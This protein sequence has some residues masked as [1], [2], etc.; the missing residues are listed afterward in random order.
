MPPLNIVD[1]LVEVGRDQIIDARNATYAVGMTDLRYGYTHPA[2]EPGPSLINHGQIIAELSSDGRRGIGVAQ[3]AGGGYQNSQ[4]WNTATGVIRISSAFEVEIYGYYTGNDMTPDFRN[5]GLFTVTSAL[6]AWGVH[7]F[8]PA[9]LVDGVEGHEFNFTNTGRLESTG[10]RNA[11]GAALYNGGRVI[12]TGEIVATGTASVVGMLIWSHHSVLFNS[13]SIIARDIAGPDNSIGLT[14]SAGVFDSSVVNTGLIS[15][16]TAIKELVPGS[17]FI[18]FPNGNDFIDNSG[19][20]RGD[21]VFTYGSDR[22]DNSGLIVGSVTFTEGD[23]RFFGARGRLFGD[24]VLGAGNDW[25]WSGRAN[26]QV[27]GGDGDD[28]ISG[29]FGDDVLFAGLG[30]DLLLGEE[31]ND[32]LTG[33]GG[34]DALI[35]GEGNDI[36][37]SDGG[38]L[39]SGGRGEDLYRLGTGRDVVVLETGSGADVVEGFDISVDRFQLGGQVFTGMTAIG[40]DTLLVHGGG[41]VLIRGVTGLSLSGWNALATGASDGR[42]LVGE[43]ASDILAGA[44]GR[45]VLLGAGGD[46]QLNG[47]AGDDLLDG[48]DGY[49]ELEGGDGDDHLTDHGGGGRLSGGAGADVIFGSSAAETLL[50]GADGDL[51]I[52]GGGNDVLFGDGAADSLLGGDGNDLID[53]GTGANALYGEAG[54]DTIMGGAD[55]EL[56]RGGIGD[57]VIH[58][59]GGDDLLF[60][61][62]GDDLIHGGSGNDKIDSV[63][64]NSTVYGG[65]GNDSI[66]AQGVNVYLY[67]GDGD[68]VINAVQSRWVDVNGGAGDDLVYAS[69]Y[70]LTSGGDGNDQVWGSNLNDRLQ[71]GA[72]DDQISGGGGAGV[73]TADYSDALSYVTIDLKISG[74]QDTHGSGRDY[75]MSIANLIG[76]NHDDVLIGGFGSSQFEGGAGN[77]RLVGEEGDDRLL[78]G[79]GNDR[80]EGGS[81]WDILVGGTG[82]DSQDGGEGTDWAIFAG[83]RSEYVITTNGLITSVSGADGSDTLTSVEFLCFTDGVYSVSGVAA[84]PNLSGTPGPDVISGSDGD[85]II[86]GLAGDDRIS[87]NRGHNLIDGGAGLDTVVFL[88]ARPNYQIFWHGEVMVIS[89]SLSTFVLMGVERVRFEEQTF[90]ARSGGGLYLTDTTG[91][92]QLFGEASDDEM[93]AGLGKDTLRAGDGAD[94]L[95]GGAGD[96]QL[97]GQGG[98]D[99]LDGGAGD[100]TVDGGTGTDRFLVTGA[101]SNYVLLRDGDVLILKGTDGSDRLSGVEF[102]QFGDGAV[103]DIAR[104]YGEGD[105]PL[106]LPAADGG[107]GKFAGDEPL[108]LPG[109]DEPVR[110]PLFTDEVRL[111]GQAAMADGAP[112]GGFQAERVGGGWGAD[113]FLF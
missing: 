64:G 70:G 37:I 60:G 34:L 107:G 80:L 68:D 94:Q 99:R 1:V 71:G 50:G 2:L 92:D 113:G 30:D 111:P 72:G 87:E 27:F 47:G 48:G 38:N 109:A 18:P 93:V 53:G 63:A 65:D 74:P 8:G 52:G 6:D 78:G 110:P 46:D 4:I 108:V 26:D 28:Q 88:G 51:L 85:D 43:F 35:G 40:S 45:D 90:V 11:Y 5:D 62:G 14:I 33:G 20:I 21:I 59:G 79:L 22:I 81:G 39:L 58:G 13:G 29:G 7:T 77:D 103:W 106:V 84:A 96:D 73:D 69:G 100:D 83:T 42:L 19:E 56:I 76:S 41:T 104:Q 24:M 31:G 101:A 105:G 23:D 9:A 91:N 82:N 16:R 95:W 98:D 44:G 36:L 86:H 15:G 54:D 67:G 61:D 17:T 25:A 57:D 66:T 49:D 55:G 89:D 3:F 32:T 112:H 75:L 102:I 10:A 12:N 97:F